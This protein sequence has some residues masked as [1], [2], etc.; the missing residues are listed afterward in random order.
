[1][2]ERSAEDQVIWDLIQAGVREFVVC[3]GA[4]NARLVASLVALAE[5]NNT[6]GEN[7]MFQIWQHFEERGA[8]FFALGRTKEAGEPCAVIITSG[9]AVAECL[10]AVIEAH[11]SSKP[12]VIVSADRPERFQGSGAPQTIAQDELFGDYAHRGFG[13]DW[14]GQGPW[15]LNVP[16]EEEGGEV[17]PLQTEA[18]AFR[19]A[20]RKF[21]VTEVLKFLDGGVYRGLLVM[22]GGLEPEEREE[23]Y[24]FAKGLGVPVMADANSG[25]REAL[26]GQQVDSGFDMPG[27]VLRLGEVPIGRFWRDL[28]EAEETEVL[29]VCRNGLPGLARKE[30]VSVI[31]AELHRVLRSV[32]EVSF[33]GD[34]RDDLPSARRRW[35][36]RIEGLEA[37]PDSE[38]AL[39]RTLSLYASMGESLFLG[40]SLPIREWNDYAQTE[41]A[42]EVVRANR[43]ANGID[44]QVSTWLGASAYEKGAWGVFG[45]LT[46]LYDLAAPAMLDQVEREGRVLV[47]VNN[48]G[49]RIFDRLPRLDELTESQRS[50]LVQG[51][52]VVLSAW[53]Q[54]W[55][56]DYLRIENQD[57]FD[58]L[59][60]GEKTLLVEVI[61]REDS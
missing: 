61:P 56:M 55:G 18:Q 4:R 40:N 23:V 38:A 19:P 14:T 36:Q 26:S 34:V 21:S 22:I 20:R 51:Q 32:G 31:Q 57:G 35:N 52:E 42:Y 16:L 60:P 48:G 30:K 9:T 54:M 41:V 49:G 58:E 15:H 12:L 53:A 25:L 37:F 5:E 28:E 17:L 44:G 43:G 45:D 6:A 11:Y 24:H 39:V 50:A 47:V 59:H 7:P 27:R 29:S 2:T 46:A 1:M 10:P 13:G 33:I 8:A 3:G